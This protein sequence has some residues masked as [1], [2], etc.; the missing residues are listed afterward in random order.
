MAASEPTDEHLSGAL[1][2]LLSDTESL[3][4][5][6]LGVDPQE[7]GSAMGRPLGPTAPRARVGAHRA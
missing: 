5:T 1:D 7:G 2:D 3:T 4:R 6:L